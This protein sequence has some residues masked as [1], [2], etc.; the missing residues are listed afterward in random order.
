[1]CTGSGG[2]LPKTGVGRVVESVV[3]NPDCKTK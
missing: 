3:E 2:F 1:M